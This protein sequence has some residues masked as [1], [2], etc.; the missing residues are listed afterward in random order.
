MLPSVDVYTLRVHVTITILVKNKLCCSSS[1]IKAK[2]MKTQRQIVAKAMII[3]YNI[4]QKMKTEMN[5]IHSNSNRSSQNKIKTAANKQK[6]KIIRQIIPVAI[7]VAVVPSPLL[8][9]LPLQ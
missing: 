4:H 8:L 3:M 1:N 5:Y 6:K 9:T 7:I 2:R